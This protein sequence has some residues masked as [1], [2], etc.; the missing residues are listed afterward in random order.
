MVLPRVEANTGSRSAGAPPYYLGSEIS[1][2][3]LS[4]DACNFS[5]FEYFF[6]RFDFLER[7]NRELSKSVVRSK[8]YLKL[9]KLQVSELNK[10]SEISDPDLEGGPSLSAPVFASTLDKQIT[11]FVLLKL[12]NYLRI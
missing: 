5:S 7:S 10:I 12:C 9:A 6:D 11:S 8:K 4:S 3:L 2:I 1:E